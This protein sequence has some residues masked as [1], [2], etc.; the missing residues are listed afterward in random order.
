[1][2][3]CIKKLLQ[4]NQKLKEKVGSL[5]SYSRRG[6]VKLLRVQETKGENCKALVFKLFQTAGTAV[7]LSDI[8]TA[9]RIRAAN[10]PRPIIIQFLYPEQKWQLLGVRNLI[11]EKLKIIVVDDEPEG[12][13]IAKT[14]LLPIM[15]KAKNELGIS[16]SRVVGDKET[17]NDS[18]Y[19][20][21][22]LS[23]L[24][25]QLQPQNVFTVTRRIWLNFSPN[26]L[27]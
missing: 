27:L 2:V 4:E 15:R 13:R 21:D 7:P 22:T 11:K 1:M 12:V 10:T 14:V 19:T 25:E 5:E 3:D 24:P 8:V 20:L 6:D 18:T 23:L 26:H 17:T 16:R 9:H